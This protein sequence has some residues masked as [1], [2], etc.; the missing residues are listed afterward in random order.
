MNTTYAPEAPVLGQDTPRPPKPRVCF[1]A[2][3]TWP[4]ISGSRDIPIIGGAELQQSVIAPELARR[5]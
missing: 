2:P 3:T 1:L 5:G 4:L